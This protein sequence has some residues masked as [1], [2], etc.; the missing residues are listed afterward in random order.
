MQNPIPPIP[1]SNSLRKVTFDK[2]SDKNKRDDR[3]KFSL[4]ED[5]PERETTETP[6]TEHGPV[7][8]NDPTEPGGRLDVT[9]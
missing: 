8:P 9:G 7:A 6:E 2:N 3:A 5:E 4:D 1:P